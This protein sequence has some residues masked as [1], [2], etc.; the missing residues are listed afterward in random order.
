MKK[1]LVR[2][3]HFSREVQRPV[4]VLLLSS[5]L[6][7]SFTQFKNIGTKLEILD[8]QDSPYQSIKD[9][10]KLD[11]SFSLTN[12]IDF[13][14]SKS[15][16]FTGKDLC[17]LQ[18]FS[19]KLSAEFNTFS[20]FTLRTPQ[21]KEG[22]LWYKKE[23]YPCNKNLSEL[24]PQDSWKK[25]LWT[26]KDII[27]KARFNDSQIKNGT[28]EKIKK[29]FEPLKEAGFSFYMGS[30]S[31]LKYYFYKSVKKDSFV[32]LLMI[33]LLFLFFL[34]CYRNLLAFFYTFLS[35][36]I[37]ISLT[38]GIMGFLGFD[39]TLINNGLFLMLAIATVQD[40]VF[41][42]N[43]YATQKG[44]FGES[45]ENQIL[46]C[47]LTTFT[48]LVGFLSLSFSPLAVINQFG[49]EAAIGALIEW[50]VVFFI[51]PHLLQIDKWKLDVSHLKLKI[52][53]LPH[54]PKKLG[55]LLLAL[56]PLC[57]FFM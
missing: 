53:H 33:L 51:C 14:V 5:V 35:L 45:L 25:I 7:W 56:L 19:R 13:I 28:L 3:L 36:A 12:N 2:C 50:F 54:L 18:Q 23:T 4:V 57:F 52:P 55:I 16:P 41:L 17:Y 26:E 37:S 9:L 39:I 10:N 46:P 31:A 43:D 20:L 32:N 40:I 15:T 34:F 44:T 8:F 30:Q 48:T 27:F 11:K 49:I 29:R 42:F 22:K 21:L 1:T 6:L 24:F 47:F 38:L